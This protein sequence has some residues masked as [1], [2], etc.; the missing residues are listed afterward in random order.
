MQFSLHMLEFLVILKIE[1]VLKAAFLNGF[2]DLDVRIT[3][4]DYEGENTSR[5]NKFTKFLQEEI[6]N[7]RMEWMM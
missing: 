1:H 6:L 4:Y 2:R 7:G 5:L 3:P